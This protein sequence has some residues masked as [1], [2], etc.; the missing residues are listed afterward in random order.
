MKAWTCEY[1]GSKWP[2]SILKCLTCGAVA[3][4]VVE[5][6]AKSESNYASA[7]Q[8]KSLAR[9][10]HNICVAYTRSSLKLLSKQEATN[11]VTSTFQHPSVTGG[12]FGS[13]A[14]SV[15]SS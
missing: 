10:Y 11:L 9:L 7:A 13:S 3:I 5:A 2:P 8:V 14:L 4:V 6:P 12:S 1:C 15:M